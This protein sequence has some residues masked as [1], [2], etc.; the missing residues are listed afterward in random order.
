MQQSSFFVKSPILSPKA[1]FF[2]AGFMV[3]LFNILSR[4]HNTEPDEHPDVLLTTE[5]LIKVEHKNISNP[6]LRHCWSL[7]RFQTVAAL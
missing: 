5:T 4:L 3:K 1:V 6:C 2:M 7:L